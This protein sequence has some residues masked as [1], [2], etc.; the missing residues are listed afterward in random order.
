MPAQLVGDGPLEHEA[1]AA[2]GHR[3]A[4]VERVG[5]DLGHG[6]L[7]L[8]EEVAHLGAVAVD[9]D[10][11]VAL[12]DDV[13]HEPGRLLGVLDL[14]GLDAPLVL[15][16][17]GVAAEGDQGD[18]TVDWHGPRDQNVLEH[19]LEVGRAD[20]LE[21]VADGEQGLAGLDQPVEVDRRAADDEVAVDPV[22]RLGQLLDLVSP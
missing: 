17:H 8:D 18:A 13:D 3:V 10:E 4:D 21:L 15:G 22:D 6:L 9:D 16:Q 19:V 2:L 14:F 11:L 7:H 5:R 12:A 1:H 20:L